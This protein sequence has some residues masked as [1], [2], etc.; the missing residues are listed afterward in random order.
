MK[1]IFLI[2]ISLAIALNIFISL[3]A[4]RRAFAQTKIFLDV[5]EARVRRSKLAIPSFQNLSAKVSPGDES[6][7][8]ELFSVINNDL[9]VT[10]LFAKMDPKSFLEDTS[11]TGLRPASSAPNGFQFTTWKSLETEFLIRGG[12]Q[13]V[14]GK[15][16][17]EIYAYYVPQGQLILGKKYDGPTKNAYKI[18][19]TFANDFIKAVTGKPSFFNSQIVVAIDGGASTNREIYIADWDGQHATPITSHNTITVSPAWS[20]NG[21]FVAYTAYVKRKIGAGPAKRNPDLFIYELKTKRRWLV[22]Y[23]DGL[24]SG[25]EFLPDN[26]NLLLTLSFN[27]SADIYKMTLDGKSIS[28]LTKGPAGAMNVEPAISPDGNT[29]AFSSDRSGQ[30]MIYTMNMAGGN[31]KR[32]TFAGHYN[33]TPTWSNDG[34]K[35][36]FAGFDREKNN[37]DV[38]VMNADGTEMLRL[39]SAK[40]ANGKWANNED[41]AFSPDGRQVMFISDRVGNKQLYMVNVDGSNERRISYDNKYYSKPK[42]GP[43][44]E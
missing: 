6:A 19:H 36:A 30:P 1:R 42:W 22:S 17:L 2:C 33:S 4:D 32:H 39:T 28:Q 27:K 11:S 29:I 16:T 3:S 8:Y 18:G 21:E 34:K 20:K 31:V 37:F 7:G 15:I 12:Y 41:P 35:I 9:D 5:G 43:L 40:K 26:K 23:R 14:N 10:G 25:A 44:I 38:F 13:V 24:N